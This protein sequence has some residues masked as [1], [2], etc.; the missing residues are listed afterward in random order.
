MIT[1][2]KNKIRD[3]VSYKTYYKVIA[4]I[5]IKK[6]EDVYLRFLIK[7]KTE[8]KKDD[9]FGKIIC[10]KNNAGFTFNTQD[11]LVLLNDKEEEDIEIRKTKKKD[12]EYF[13]ERAI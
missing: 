8:I 7:F 3:N 10:G 9:I 5:K 12:F 4:I 1:H 6:K 13:V 11:N 2:N